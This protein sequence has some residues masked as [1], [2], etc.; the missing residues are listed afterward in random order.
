M[1]C[2]ECIPFPGKSGFLHMII[3]VFSSV[4]SAGKTHNA[5]VFI[6]EEFCSTLWCQ[7]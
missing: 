1:S 5:K 4:S 7:V 6:E 2:N 3:T